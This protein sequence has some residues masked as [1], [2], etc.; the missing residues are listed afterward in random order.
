MD[1]Q[2]AASGEV[3]PVRVTIPQEGRLL[4]FTR[5]LQ[6][7]PDSEMRI[8]FTA[9]SGAAT[10]WIVTGCIALA[11]AMLFG[12]AARFAFGRAV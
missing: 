12:F 6:V 10:G 3:H 4:T 9:G 11:I 7:Q 8:E 5:E 2:V 1:Q